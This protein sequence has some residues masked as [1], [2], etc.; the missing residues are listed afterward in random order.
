M[1]LEDW[2]YDRCNLCWYDDSGASSEL[3]TLQNIVW[4]PNIMFFTTL[5]LS[6]TLLC[7]EKSSQMAFKKNYT[8]IMRLLHLL[9]AQKII[10]EIN[11][12]TVNAS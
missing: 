1:N 12:L 10:F 6:Q 3:E 9:N 11:S 4:E 7:Y 8:K 5:I 2:A